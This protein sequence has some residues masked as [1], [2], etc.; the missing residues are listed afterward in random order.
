MK[1][2]IVAAV[3]AAWAPAIHADMVM[4]GERA[5]L[6]LLET[7]CAPELLDLLDPRF[8]LRFR[9][10]AGY[11]KNG[12]I[13]VACWAMANAETILVKFADGS[14]RTYDLEAFTHDPGI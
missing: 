6:R 5:T 14:F 10:A 7:P 4:R 11:R 9:A 13:D 1:A 8:H 3:L 12:E 2:I